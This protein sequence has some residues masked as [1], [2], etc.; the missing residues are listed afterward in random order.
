[1]CSVDDDCVCLLLGASCGTFESTVTRTPRCKLQARGD[2]V[3]FDESMGNAGFIS[4][5]WVAKQHP[6][7]EFMQ[8]KVLQDVLRRLLTTSGS[9]PLDVI[10][11]SFTRSA[12]S[13]SFEHFQSRPLFLWYDYFSVP[14][15][16][17]A[18]S[19]GEKDQQA[20]AINSIPAYV[21]K[22]TFFFALCATIDSPFEGKVLSFSTWAL[23]GW[24]RLE[25]A[26][27]ELSANDGWIVI[28]SPAALE[29]VGAA[30]SCGSVG[31]GAFTLQ[32]DL[33]KLAAVLRAIVKRKLIM[34]LQAG[35]FPSYRRH[36]N[37]QAVH[38]RR[39]NVEPVSVFPPNID[40]NSAKDEV[41]DF[42]YENGLT[43]VDCRD[44]AGWWPLH[45]AAMSG[46]VTLIKALLTQRVN[47]NRRTS[48]DEPQLGLAP[49]LSALDLAML[50]RHN[51]A[52]RLLIDARAQLQGGTQP[53]MVLAA[54]GDNMEGIRLLCGAGGNPLSKDIFGFTALN[55]AAGNNCLA[56]IDELVRQ[57]NPCQLE[58]SSALF[59][60][61]GVQGGSAEVVE[62]LIMLRADV[63][64]QFDARNHMNTLG[65]LF[66]GA[67]SLQHSLGSST[68][69][70]AM[71]YH[72]YGMT[73]LMAALQSAQHEG[74][75]ALIAAG[76]RLDIKNCRGWT[77]ADFARGHAIPEWLQKGLEGDPSECRRVSSLA[78]P[79]GH[80]QIHF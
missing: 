79:D 38:L 64:F 49:W 28:K 69:L 32:G 15:L 25:R 43:K 77:A 35:D 51:D 59:T 55:C 48:R 13:I 57:G 1:M 61:M 67:K 21:V 41:A 52:A 10:T 23:R 26:C 11:E 24:C 30:L 18:G 58:L 44:S 7:P 78:V 5:E 16:D 6:D 20:K 73:P 36:L 39:L 45:Y 2:V 3:V 46:K 29:V 27:R 9:V 22:C 50:W 80:V 8:M 37:L 74:A 63:N 40:A 31:E 76:A 75:A 70:A 12:R 65:R 54:S 60:A 33:A 17:Q 53:A 34:S 72:C 56:A 4:H 66:H 47:P 14:Q 42:L 62:R 19:E 68:A 71:A